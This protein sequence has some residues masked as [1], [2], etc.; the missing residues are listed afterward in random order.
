MNQPTLED[1]RDFFQSF[2]DYNMFLL[3]STMC[4]LKWLFFFF[5]NNENK[6]IVPVGSWKILPTPIYLFTVAHPFSFFFPSLYVK[7][8]AELLYFSVMKGSL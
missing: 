5:F 2:A 8:L 7:S 1:K 6:I 3:H 4:P